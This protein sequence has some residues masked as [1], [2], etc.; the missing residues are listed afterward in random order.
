MTFMS[1]V[2]FWRESF[3][4]QT[5]R[6]SEALSPLKQNI[7]CPIQN[8]FCGVAGYKTSNYQ[9]FTLEYYTSKNTPVSVEVD[10]TGWTRFKKKK[11][12]LTLKDDAVKF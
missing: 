7:W 9:P 5:L 6:K 11:K 4:W 3:L 10:D 8:S 1:V 2:C 12:H